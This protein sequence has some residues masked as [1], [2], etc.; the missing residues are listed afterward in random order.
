MTRNITSPL[1]ALLLTCGT[2]HASEWVSLGKSTDGTI[3]IL[4]DVSSIRSAGG[5]AAL[6]SP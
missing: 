4:I 1:L 2:A 3:E 5:V 6:R